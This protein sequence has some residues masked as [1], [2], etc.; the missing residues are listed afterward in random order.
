MFRSCFKRGLV[1]GV[2]AFSLCGML[3]SQGRAGIIVPGTE[4]AHIDFAADPVFAPVGRVEGF[5]GSVWRLLGTGTLVK[6]N[7]VLTAG[8]VPPATGYTQ[9]RFSLGPSAFLPNTGRSFVSTVDILGIGGNPVDPDLAVLT[10]TDPITSVAPAT[11]YMG[12]D[13][14]VGDRVIFADY[15]VLGYYPSG[16]LPADGIKR[17]GEN[18]IRFIGPDAVLGPDR[19]LWDFGP[20]NGTPSLLLE[21]NGSNLSSGGGTFAFIEDE[22]QLV[23]VISGAVPLRQT[24]AVRPAVHADWTNQMVGVPEP[25][26]FLLVLTSVPFFMLLKS[27]QRYRKCT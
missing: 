7:K 22:W 3:S 1:L 10:L 19:I 20:A 15:G 27:Y 21:Q 23:A 16:E 6:D 12:N 4:Q 9:F 13:I 17:A 8:H 11:I 2:V 5:D 18:L 25:S 24:L 26:T 14:N